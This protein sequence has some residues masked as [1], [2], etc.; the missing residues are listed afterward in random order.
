MNMKGEA[1][2]EGLLLALLLLKHY[3]MNHHTINTSSYLC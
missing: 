3:V 2:I 1:L